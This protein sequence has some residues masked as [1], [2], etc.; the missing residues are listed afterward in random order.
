MAEFHIVAKESMKAKCS[1]E[2]LLF[3]ELV[4]AGAP[5]YKAGT[6][7]PDHLT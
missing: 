5:V 2:Q 6:P 1:D 3:L 4:W 7:A